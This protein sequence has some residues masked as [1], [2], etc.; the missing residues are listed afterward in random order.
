MDTICHT[1]YKLSCTKA[2]DYLDQAGRT[3]SG[4]SDIV[5]G[6]CGRIP[7]GRPYERIAELNNALGRQSSFLA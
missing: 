1:N 6:T 7:K 5:E 3:A 2:F 4:N